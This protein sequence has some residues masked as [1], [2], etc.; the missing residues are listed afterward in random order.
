MVAIAAAVAFVFGSAV[1]IA[2]VVGGDDAGDGH[3]GGHA[4]ERGDGH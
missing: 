3:G 2:E 1:L 4:M